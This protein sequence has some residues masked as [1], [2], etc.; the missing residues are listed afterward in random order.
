MTCNG[1]LA[2]LVAITAPSGYVEPI[3]AVII[4]IVAG[5]LVVVFVGLVDKVFHID[6][7][8]GAISV[9]G[10]NGMWG[11]LA[12]GL[13][14]DNKAQYLSVQG[15]FYGGGFNQLLAQLVG[16][17]VAFAWAFGISFAFFKVLGLIIGGNRVSEA[18]ELGGLDEGEMVQPGYM[19]SD[20][21]AGKWPYPGVGSPVGASA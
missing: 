10:V 19:D 9:H 16:A 2:G 1:L 11:Q 7:P 8:V 13:F 20:P 5:G 18:M 4:G 6:D 14:A 17:V 15:L 21:L 12:V 3:A